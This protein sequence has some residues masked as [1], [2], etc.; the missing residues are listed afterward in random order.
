[1]SASLLA[2]YDTQAHVLVFDGKPYLVGGRWTP[3]GVDKPPSDPG[4]AARQIGFDPNRLAYA[5]MPATKQI[6]WYVFPEGARPQRGICLANVLKQRIANMH[7]FSFPSMIMLN[8]EQAA[9]VVVFD[10]EGAILPDWERWAPDFA[11]L[12]EE[13]D[14]NSG[15][16]GIFRGKDSKIIDDPAQAV[17]WLFET[18]QPKAPH[19]VEVRLANENTRMARRLMLGGVALAALAVA[20]H[21][22]WQRYEQ[23]VAAHKAAMEAAQHAK[24]AAF[25]RHERELAQQRRLSAHQKL[26]DYWH[27]FPRPW[28]DAPANQAVLETCVN[29]VTTAPAFDDGWTRSGIACAVHGHSMTVSS[30][31]TRGPLATVLDK[32]AG[33]IGKNGQTVT[34][35][36]TLPLPAATDPATAANGAPRLQQT[37]DRSG[38]ADPAGQPWTAKAD[39]RLLGVQN[40]YLH[41]LGYAQRYAGVVA[42][43]VHG[44]HTA[45]RPPVPPFIKGKKKIAKIAQETPV[46]WRQFPISASS[47][48]APDQ[49]WPLLDRPGFVITKISA[50]A[51]GGRIGSWQMSGVQYAR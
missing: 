18:Y 43:S 41:W 28:A 9:W 44:A 45:F 50:Q 51:H 7:E 39:G 36:V 30:T 23:R 27:D 32:P 2:S 35:S 5:H 24:M 19:R 11:S 22:G 21:Y 10:S 49:G 13:V 34:G 4:R 37:A 3:S 38:A 40:D 8:F 15:N 48:L 42:I 47:K 25:E 33:A 31:W 29:Q 17:A 14:R 16:I 46:L 20:G 1:M 12:R 6:G 26:I